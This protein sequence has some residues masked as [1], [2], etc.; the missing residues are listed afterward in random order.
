MT[1]THIK[2]NAVT[3]RVQ[4]TGN[5]STTV[6][7][8][9]FAIFDETDMVVYLG[10]EVQ[11][12]GYSVSGAGQTDGGNVTFDTAPEDGV[13]ITLLRSIPIER[14]TDFQEGGTFRPKNLNDE[15]DRQTAFLQQVQE[16]LDRSVKVGPTS[17]VDPETVLTEVEK[18]Y[19]DIDNIDAVADNISNVNAVAGNATNINAVAGN[20]TNINAVVG[21]S[22]NINTVAGSDANI[23]TVATNIS[24]VSDC[25]DNM[26]AILD[27]PNQARAAADSAA[28]AYQYGNDKI[29]QTHISNCITEIPQDIK[30]ELHNGT[31][32][33]KAG[34]KVY[35]PNG[36]GV[37]DEVTIESDLIYNNVWGDVDK[38]VVCVKSDGT[39]LIRTSLSRVTSG[40]SAPT[41]TNYRF[42]YDTT[43]NKIKE[44][45]SGSW[46]NTILSF[47]VAIV[48]VPGDNT[49]TVS[50]IDQVFNGFGYIGKTLFVL[51]GLKALHANGRNSDGTLKSDLTIVSNVLTYTGGTNDNNSSEVI[52]RYDATECQLAANIKNWEYDSINNYFY[53]K[54]NGDKAWIEIGRYISYDNKVQSMFRKTVFHALDWNDKSTI[55][56]WS[57]PSGNYIDLTLGAS[58]TEYTAPANGWFYCNK[59]A[60]AT[61]KYMS[62]I[63]LSNDL[64]AEANPTGSG[65][66]ARVYVPVRRGDKVKIGYS[67]TGSTQTFRFI[68]AEGEV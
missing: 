64:S 5:G 45:N 57:M 4:Y 11:E 33:L 25:A 3:P 40:T 60:G 15:F 48:S 39:E 54:D 24:D 10:D 18:I 27:A 47:P 14:V 23:G 20:A 13:K 53:Y 55:S 63:N 52:L 38:I 68:Y 36:S 35:V 44:Y 62:M 26:S 41:E 67:V 6:F 2:I 46:T 66:S 58:E 16:T 17:D 50:S 51:P 56:G 43:A 42:W 30:L 7:P 22:T 9:E 12:S 31:L 28:L 37:F 61:N 29:N 21:N 19:E 65:N 59:T 32:T 34:S 8:Y 49:S 1:D